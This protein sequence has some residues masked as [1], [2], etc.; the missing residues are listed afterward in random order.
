MAMSGNVSSM[1]TLT[2][3]LLTHPQGAPGALAGMLSDL[4][5]TA[6]KDDTL[7]M[8]TAIRL[9]ATDGLLHGWSTDRYRAAHAIVRVEGD[10]PPVHLSRRDA[11]AAAKALRTAPIVEVS[12]TDDK[13]TFSG[14]GVTLTYTTPDNTLPDSLIKALPEDLPTE[15][16]GAQFPA[17]FLADFAAIGK[18]RKEYVNLVP[19]TGVRP[20]HI[21]IGD[22]YRAWLMPLGRARTET[23]N[24]PVWVGHSW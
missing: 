9:H 2:A 16:D 17:E 10:L 7:P 11:E 4:A 21:R 22:D 20:T 24:P 6:S 12:V 18:R 13:L 19:S 23:A 15:H 1:T 5:K 8:F 3:K 14:A